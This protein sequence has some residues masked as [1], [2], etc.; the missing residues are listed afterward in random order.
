MMPIVEVVW[1]HLLAGASE[2]RRRWSSLGAV[3][4]ELDLGVSTVHRSLMH[5][6]EI[7]AVG[8]LAGGG[9]QVLDPYRLLVLFAAHRHVQ[10]EIVARHRVALGV[11][12]LEREVL[13]AGGI[14][15]AFGAVVAHLGVNRIADYSTVVVY[16]NA[17]RG[18]GLPA[19]GQADVELLTVAPD[20]WIDRYGEVT[21]LAHAYADLF[22]LPGW[23]AARFVSELDPRA[24]AASDEPVLLI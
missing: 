20:R 10:R 9:V 3:A 19:G 21:T 6:A 17:R 24:I 13:D 1:R 11:E 16:A 23:Q 2:G 15:G 22:C 14:L 4:S 18:D 12:Q 5:P 8:T 7:G